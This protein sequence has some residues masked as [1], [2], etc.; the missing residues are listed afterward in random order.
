M[1]GRPGPLGKNGPLDWIKTAG[2]IFIKIPA[3]YLKVAQSESLLPKRQR[4][5]QSFDDL[6]VDEVASAS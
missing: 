4:R 3:K 2:K 5:H 6:C 1:S